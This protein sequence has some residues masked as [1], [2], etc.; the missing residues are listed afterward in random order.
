MQPTTSTA[1]QPLTTVY[2]A[3]DHVALRDMFRAQLETKLGYR[4]IGESSDG[5]AVARECLSL[6]PDVLVLD[7]GLPSADGLE[8]LRQLKAARSQTRVLVFSSRQEPAIVRQVVEAGAMGVVEKTAPAETV[9]KAVVEVAAG[10]TFFGEGAAGA[11]QRS[12]QNRAEPEGASTLTARE[13]DV[14]QLVAAGRTNKEVADLLG[15][16]VKTAENH[17]HNLMTKLSAHNAADLTRVAFELGL[18]TPRE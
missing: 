16:S 12:L 8:V 3:E 4:V 1:E 14:L 6:K 17:R 7:L 2:L 9:L 18:V 10:R 15:I 11:L 13:R 5:T